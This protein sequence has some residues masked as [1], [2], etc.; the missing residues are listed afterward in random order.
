MLHL[1]V[2]S[3]RLMVVLLHQLLVMM[4]VVV[5]MVLVFRNAIGK[6]LVRGR[7]R[8]WM[9]TVPD[10]RLLLNAIRVSWGAGGLA[11]VEGVPGH[12][13]GVVRVVLVVRR[14]RRTRVLRMMV[15]L[16]QVVL[17]A[18]HGAWMIVV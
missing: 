5:M 12:A 16:V 7:R 9:R 18:I 10:V 3:I 11:A 6:H 13:V 4:Q 15:G 17:T 1:H 8:P 2:P 14:G